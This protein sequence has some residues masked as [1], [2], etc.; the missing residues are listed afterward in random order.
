MAKTDAEVEADLDALSTKRGRT[1]EGD[2][3]DQVKALFD[4]YGVWYWMVVKMIFG[5]SGL[6]DFICCAWGYFL[7]VETKAKNGKPTTLQGIVLAAIAKAGG[8]CFIINEHNLSELETW[9]KS[10]QPKR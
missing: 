10:K 5:K 7:A 4:V 3:K 9:L 8:K 1:P 2:V 6:P